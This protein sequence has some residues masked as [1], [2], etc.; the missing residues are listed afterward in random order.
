MF[1]IGDKVKCIG[2]SAE[3]EGL[4]FGNE[5]TIVEARYNGKTIEVSPGNKGRFWAACLFEPIKWIPKNGEAIEVRDKIGGTWHKSSF[6]G[7]MTNGDIAAESRF[8]LL[9][10]RMCRKPTNTHLITI[11]GREIELSEESYKAFEKQFLQD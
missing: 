10:W 11:D 5:Y 1:K 4:V 3:A 6:V 2:G 7:L 9:P 8:G